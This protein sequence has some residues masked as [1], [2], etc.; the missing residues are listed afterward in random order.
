[1]SGSLSAEFT[2]IS[3]CENPHGIYLYLEPCSGCDGG[4][5]FREVQTA[6]REAPRHVLP[7][8]FVEGRVR[9]C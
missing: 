2:F 5:L 3:F 7:E 6:L 4:D 8:L 9:P 1:M